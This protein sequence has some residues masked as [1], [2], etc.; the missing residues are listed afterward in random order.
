MFKNSIWAKQIIEAQKEDG[1]FGHFHSLSEPRK[2]PL[3]TEQALRRLEIL[4]YTIEDE[5]IIKTVT[6]MEKCLTKEF[7]ITDIKET[8]RH[9]ENFVDLM[10]ATWIIRFK[11]NSKPA[12]RIKNIWARITTKTFSSGEYC[13]EDFSNAYKEEF[14]FYDKKSIILTMS[15]FYNVSILVDALD[16]RTEE[17]FFDYV[18]NNPMGIY[19]IYPSIIRSTPECI[20][21]KLSSKYLGAIELLVA[22][23]RNKHKLQFVI[24]WLMDNKSNSESWD[25]GSKIKDGFYMPLSNDWRKRD[26]RV[27]DCTHRIN[28]LIKEIQ[29]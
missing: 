7:E 1:S 19:Y 21:G 4:G 27:K 15:R 9:W 16:K 5:V 24:E 18:L 11:K 22:Y 3:T 17:V 20:E 14:G 13:I 6:Y 23:K 2:S 8:H 29:S 26:N 12:N 10:L 28:S 25:M